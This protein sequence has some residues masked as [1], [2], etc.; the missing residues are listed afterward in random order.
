MR[1][2]AVTLKEHSCKAIANI[3]TVG[4][5]KISLPGDDQERWF[6]R[7]GT[8]LNEINFC[9]YCG[10]DLASLVGEGKP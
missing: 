7:F 3:D 8:E 1:D 5:E 4:V 2:K 9:P 6:L 10:I